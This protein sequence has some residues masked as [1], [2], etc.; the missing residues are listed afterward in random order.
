MEYKVVSG[1]DHISESPTTFTDRVPASMKD[2]VP[3]TKQDEEGISYYWVGGEK[4]RWAN[5][6]VKDEKERDVRLS[7]G[8]LLITYAFEAPGQWDLKQRMRDYDIDGIDAAILFPNQSLSGLREVE[9]LDVRLACFRAFNDWVIEEVS[10]FAPERLFGLALVPQWD[11]KLA[12]Q[13]AVRAVEMGHR[14]VLWSGMNDLMG[15]KPTWDTY[16]DPLYSTL[17]DL[18]VPLAVHVGGGAYRGLG[19]RAREDKPDFV[20]TSLQIEGVHSTMYPLIEIL[21]SGMLERFPRLKVFFGE[22]GVSW[23]PYTLLQCDHYWPRY[24][25]FDKNIL[26]MP[27]SEYARRQIS[28]TFFY[29]L[30]TPTVVEVLGEDNIMW[31]ADYAHTVT[32]FPRSRHYQEESLKAITDPTLR[33]KILAGNAVK[34][35]KLDEPAVRGAKPKRLS[36]VKAGAAS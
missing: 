27:P 29:D 9:D 20:M 21:M 22:A 24:T 14:G 18:G 32:T 34:R 10:G 26:R 7:K 12:V 30:V 23:V 8:G 31:E 28:H 3:Y 2:K 4:V 35:F 36:R 1:D 19:L 13:E 25:P 33:A 16:W 17:E 5:H 11:V 6:V 15:Y